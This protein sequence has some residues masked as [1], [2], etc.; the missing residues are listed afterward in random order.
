MDKL[1]S[2]LRAQIVSAERDLDEARRE[3]HE[4]AA[5]RARIRAATLEEVL[6]QSMRIEP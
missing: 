6:K 5:F 4:E 1:Q 2:W 3:K